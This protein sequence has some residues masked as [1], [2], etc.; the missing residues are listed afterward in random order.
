[1]LSHQSMAEDWSDLPKVREENQQIF[2]SIHSDENVILN[3]YFII[4]QIFNIIQ[5]SEWL[6]RLN[7]R[8]SCNSAGRNL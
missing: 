5:L 8:P 1:M 2:D 3:S 4:K 6:T 7:D